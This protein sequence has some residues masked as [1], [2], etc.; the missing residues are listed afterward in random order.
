MRKCSIDIV[1]RGDIKR[2]TQQMEQR[3]ITLKADEFD[4]FMELCINAPEPN[5]KLK[6]LRRNIMPRGDGTGP[7]GAGPRT[8]RG[9]GSCPPVKVSQP[10][11]K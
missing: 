11:K 4:R 7:S 8:G 9:A 1:F 10:K 6:G 2:E 5:N 3:Y